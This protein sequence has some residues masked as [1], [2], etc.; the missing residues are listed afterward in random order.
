MPMPA[1][2][3]LRVASGLF[4]SIGPLTLTDI[5]SP[6]ESTKRRLLCER[7][8][9]SMRKGMRDNSLGCVRGPFSAM[10]AGVAQA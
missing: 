3:A 8:F 10:K 7:E 6:S 1:R 2:A 5:M 4:T 9:V